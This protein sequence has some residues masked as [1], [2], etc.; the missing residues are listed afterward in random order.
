MDSAE[1][2]KR[3]RTKLGLTQEELADRLGIPRSRIGGYETRTMPPGDFILKIQRLEKEETMDWSF[4]K[5]NKELPSLKY[6]LWAWKDKKMNILDQLLGDLMEEVKEAKEK[7]E[8]G[9]V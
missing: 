3:I 6:F 8:Q 9:M 4:I 5:L 1:E 7:I 2:I